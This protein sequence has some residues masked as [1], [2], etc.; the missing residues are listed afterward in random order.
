MTVEYELRFDPVPLDLS[1][2][3]AVLVTTLLMSQNLG[4]LELSKQLFYL[5][6]SI[7]SFRI[8]S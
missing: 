8:N 6:P 3:L 7:G 4:I 5:F 2:T 1:Q